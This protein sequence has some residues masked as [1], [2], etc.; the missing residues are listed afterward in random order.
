MIANEHELG[1]GP[2]DVVKQLNE[3]LRRKHP[4]FVDDEHA[5]LG[6]PRVLEIVEQ[7][8]DARALGY[9][10]RPA[11]RS[12]HGAQRRRR[13][14]G[15]RRPATPLAPLRAR[16]SSRFRPYPRRPRPVAVQAQ[17][18]HD[19]ALL[20]RHPRA[21]GQRGLNRRCAR[22][23]GCTGG[24][25]HSAVHELALQREML[26]RR[27]PQLVGARRHQP[28]ITAP[29]RLPDRSRLAVGNQREALPSGTHVTVAELERGVDRFLATRAA[30]RVSPSGLGRS[31]AGRPGEGRRRALRPALRDRGGRLWRAAVFDRRAVRAQ[32]RAVR[33]ARTLWWGQSSTACSRPTVE[34]T[35]GRRLLPPFLSTNN[36]IV[37][38]QIASR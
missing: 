2:L 4:R 14:P 9:R 8:S 37:D 29:E 5:A 32:T 17:G 12:R 22:L 16:T 20:G 6:Q 15:N 1:V 7:R 26:G 36:A 31:A 30:R 11:T 35:G 23:A 27:V 18:L 38:E 34:L 10:R 24:G 25:S 19:A 21:S 33:R 3:L 13:E 28:P